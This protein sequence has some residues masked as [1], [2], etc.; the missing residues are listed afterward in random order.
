[1][2]DLLSGIPNDPLLEGLPDDPLLSDIPDEPAFNLPQ[3]QKP[4]IPPLKLESAPADVAAVPLRAQIDN[5]A[6][7][8]RREE[9]RARGSEYMTAA[10][11]KP[12]LS[13]AVL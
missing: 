1:M 6:E 5:A 7:N 10:M 4:E 8:A 9:A 13:T 3:I 2:K 11:E 12:Q